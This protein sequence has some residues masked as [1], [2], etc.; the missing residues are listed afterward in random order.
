LPPSSCLL[1]FPAEHEV[2]HPLYPHIELPCYVSSHSE[3]EVPHPPG[4]R[5]RPEGLYGAAA[6]QQPAHRREEGERHHE[7]VQ[8]G[9]GQGN[10]MLCVGCGCVWEVW[11]V[12][13]GEGR[14]AG[15][16][17]KHQ[18]LLPHS[19]HP[20]PHTVP[21]LAS[22]GSSSSSSSS[23]PPPPHDASQAFKKDE[24]KPAEINAGDKNGY[25]PLHFAASNGH[26]QIMVSD[27][28]HHALARTHTHT[29]SLART[30]SR[31]QG[32]HSTCCLPLYFSL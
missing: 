21:H 15:H 30:F 31:I 26:E 17:W 24:E 18:G 11:E 25:T 5:V 12:C 22:V 20:R 9:A 8:K 28:Y 32:I 16:F 6:L 14:G 29:L 27:L 3:F 1:C 7:Q 2:P 23:S 4:G 10:Q 13:G 19:K